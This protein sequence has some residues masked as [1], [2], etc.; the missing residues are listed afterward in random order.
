M[1]CPALVGYIEPDTTGNCVMLLSPW[2]PSIPS[3]G[4]PKAH[5]NSLDMLVTLENKDINVI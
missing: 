2:L 4:F 1:S 3:M 5:C